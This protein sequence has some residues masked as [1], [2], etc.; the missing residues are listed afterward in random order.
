MLG[1]TWWLVCLFIDRAW[2]AAEEAA[3][4]K[5]NNMSNIEKDYS[6]LFSK[7]EFEK[8]GLLLYNYTAMHPNHKLTTEIKCDKKPEVWYGTRQTTNG[9][10]IFP[11]RRTLKKKNQYCHQFR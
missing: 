9:I 7:P 10:L 11:Y 1:G 8:R 3:K 4:E 6:L 5:R 2:F